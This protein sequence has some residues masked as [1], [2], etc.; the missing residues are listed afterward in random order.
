MATQDTEGWFDCAGS[1]VHV[2]YLFIH[3]EKCLLNAYYVS[4]LALEMIHFLVI[5]QSKET[6]RRR[7][8]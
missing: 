6:N 1:I 8:R 5:I 2:H 3:L 7:D 4:G